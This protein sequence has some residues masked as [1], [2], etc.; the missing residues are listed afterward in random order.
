M[1]IY[2]QHIL[3]ARDDVGCGVAGR[4]MLITRAGSWVGFRVESCTV[5]GRRAPGTCT[6][7]WRAI[8]IRF[9]ADT[10][11]ALFN[12]PWKHRLRTTLTQCATPCAPADMSVRTISDAF[13]G[14]P[15]RPRDPTFSVQFVVACRCVL[16]A[17]TMCGQQISAG[18]LTS[19]C[20]CGGLA[21][22]PRGFTT[23]RC[24]LHQECARAFKQGARQW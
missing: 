5:A 15:L 17:G 20:C 18:F 16:L 13:L 1:R 3:G 24:K 12:R 22:A 11:A 14:A 2:H 10:L 21:N 23:Q 19:C 8:C 7:R 4:W 9:A 6:G